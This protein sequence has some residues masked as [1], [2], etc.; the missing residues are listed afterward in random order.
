MSEW[1]SV[2]DHFP[3]DE[4]MVLCSGLDF[5]VGPSRHYAVLKYNNGEFAYIDDE[6]G[7]YDKWDNI[8]HW[9]PLPEP[10]K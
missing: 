7:I 4:N 2:D 3:D 10:P 8:T 6:D 9:M 5:G 1:V